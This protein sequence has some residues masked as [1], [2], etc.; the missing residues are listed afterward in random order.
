MEV[1]KKQTY[2]LEPQIGL[3]N[4]PNGLAYYKGKYHVFFQWNRFEKNH[5]YKEWGHFTS[6]NMTTWTFE[7]SALLPDQPYDKNGVYSGSSLVKNNQLYLFYTGNSKKNGERTSSQCLAV[8]EDGKTFIKKGVVLSTPEEY[9]EHFR[10][11]NVWHTENGYYMIVGAQRKSGKGAI[12]LCKS[13]DGENWKFE[14]TLAESE[15]CEMIE[16]PDILRIGQKDILL[17]CPQRRDNRKDVPLSS[18]SVYQI[19]SFDETN[20]FLSNYDLDKEQH[21]LDYGFDFYASQTFTAPDGRILLLAWMSCMEEKEEKSFGETESNIHCMTLPRELSIVD[22]E[23]CQ[24]PICEL[25]ECLRE[26]YQVKTEQNEKNITFANRRYC[27]GL[28][29][30]EPEEDFLIQLQKSEV[31]IKYD[32][33]S[34]KIHMLRMNWESKEV[35]ERACEIDPLKTM[36][37]WSDNSSVELFVNGGKRVFSARVF[38]QCENGYVRITGISDKA[39][40]RAYDVCIEERG[41]YNER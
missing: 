30:F 8:T 5:S 26:H 31:T 39:I 29:D 6:E 4:D 38:P 12:A 2:H 27:L 18:Y 11:P 40:I 22:G 32:T 25:K 21:L 28:S 37:I 33:A 14:H 20:G 24:N 13:L 35:E 36:E 41:D 15:V 9:T 17:Y 1:V 19:N 10:D 23:L 16:C 3:L 7:G 34:N